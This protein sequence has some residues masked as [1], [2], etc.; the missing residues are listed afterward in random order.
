MTEIEKEIIL[1]FRQLT[2]QEKQQFSYLCKS[3]SAQNADNA[4]CVQ[5]GHKKGEINQ[6]LTR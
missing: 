4:E 2:P 6:C 3:L 5:V 1:L